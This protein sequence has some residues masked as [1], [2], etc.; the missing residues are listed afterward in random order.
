MPRSP[1]D[2]WSI[3]TFLWPSEALLGNAAQYAQRCKRPPQEICEELRRRAGTDVLPDHKSRS[4]SP[5][6]EQLYPVVAA[7]LLPR[8]QRLMIRLIE[9][10]T[11]AENEYLTARDQNHLRRWRRARL[12]RLMQAASNPLLL[13]HALSKAEI[14]DPLDDE[15]HTESADDATV[16]L[17]NAD[18][19]LARALA[20]YQELR[21]VAGK[22]QYVANRCRELVAGGEKVV[23]WTVFLGNVSLLEEVLA[24]LRPLVITG[25]VPTYEV[26][27]D[28][29]GRTDSRE[30]HLDLQE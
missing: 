8:T 7:E 2:L 22:V 29:E 18:S 10:R 13:A 5:A 30:A 25:A 17:T 6:V 9:R 27:E 21:E 28:E 16:P 1:E 19:D 20:R 24:D 15:T 11:L 23:I 14:D 26:E 12:I 4:E 3:F